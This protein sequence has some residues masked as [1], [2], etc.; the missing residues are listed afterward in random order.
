MWLIFL[1]DILVS[2]LASLLSILLVRWVTEP[3]PGFSTVVILW[4]S[5]SLAGTCLGE[6]FVRPYRDVRRFATVR[7]M[8]KTLLT[9][10]VK[11]LVLLAVLLTGLV[12]MPAAHRALVLL[13]DVLFTV[14]LVL[15]V[16]FSVRLLLRQKADVKVLAQ[17]RTCLV[18]GTDEPSLQMAAELEKA[19]F[20]VIGLLTKDPELSGRVISDY[21][22]YRCENRDQ[23][24]RLQ[25]QLG[26]VDC[27]YFP[28]QDMEL[29]S[30]TQG[31]D[32][33]PQQDGMSL[34]GHLLKRS[35]DIG[36]SSVL[37]LI[38]S[39]VI[40]LCA[41]A[42]KR[43]DGGPVFYT[44][45][46][47]GRGGKPFLIYKFRSMRVDA[48]QFGAPALYSG[49]DD[50]RL[51]RVGR[52]LRAHHLDELP[53]LWNVLRGDMSFIGY[54]PERQYYIDQIMA[55]NARYRYLYQI[56]PGVTSYATL[57]NGYTDTLEKMLTRLDLDLYYL[58]NH[59]VW[60]DM[61]VLGLT[62]LSIV[63]GKKF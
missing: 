60:F 49:E 36:L 19:G 48:E 6:L 22:V 16:R 38:F 53:Q 54:R 62:F 47:I 63:S 4:M 43:E 23:L 11:E 51:T 39:P 7:S 61:K 37:L 45:E 17:S 3:I 30:G 8:G 5:A 42:V 24:N 26:G 14:P 25:W 2:L 13:G 29:S 35:F 1:Q 41:W 57:Y 10:L 58:R 27:I 46:R 52:F 40:G 32:S 59:S 21:V 12:R 56:R 34:V 28:K 44:Q 50:P 55:C 33:I 31:D 20:N 15:Y 18:S 9:V